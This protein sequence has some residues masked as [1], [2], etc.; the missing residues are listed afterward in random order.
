MR[1]GIPVGFRWGFGVL[2]IIAIAVIGVMTFVRVETLAAAASGVAY[3]E[4][5]RLALERSLSTLNDVEAGLRGYFM[6]RQE[7]FLQPYEAA[8]GRLEGELTAMTQ[9]A[10]YSPEQARRANELVRLARLR[11]QHLGSTLER[12]RSGRLDA[13]TLDSA[14]REGRA[15]MESVRAQV[16]AMELEESRQLQ[17]RLAA[18]ARARFLALTFTAA[19]ACVGAALVLMVLVIQSR[20]TAELRRSEQWLRTTLHSIGDAVIATDAEGM[21]RFQNDVA[22]ELT[23]WTEA[24]ARGSAL[25]EVFRIVSDDGGAVDSPVKRVLREGKIVG[26]ANH[27]LLIRRDGTRIPIE[28]SGAPIKDTRGHT[29][30]VVLVFKDAS[31]PRAAALALQSSEERLRLAL[32]AAELGTFDVEVATDRAIW[33]RQLYLMMGY[34]PGTVV[35]RSMRRAPLVPEDAEQLDRAMERA[36]ERRTSFQVEYRVARANDKVQRWHAVHGRFLY[37]EHGAPL[38]VVGVVQDVTDRRQ[39]E[40]RIRESQRLDA[41]GTLAAGIAHDFNN[42][43]AVMRGNLTLIETELAAEHPA[44]A[45]A[46]ELDAAC[47]R[48]A[49]LVRR[50]L[51]FGRRQEQDRRVVQLRDVVAETLKLLRATVP[52]SIEIRT[53]FADHIV[54]VLADVSQIHQVVMNLGINAAQAIGDRPGVITVEIEPVHVDAALVRSVPE[55]VEGNYVCLSFGDDGAGMS[56][57]VREHIF[58]PFFTTKAHGS[59]TGLGLSVVRGIVRNHDGAI[60]VT[61]EPGKGTRFQL[62]F[63]AVAEGS[64]EAAQAPRNAPATATLTSGAGLRVLFLDDEQALVGLAARLLQRLGYTVSGFTQAALA[65]EAFAAAPD[66][67]DIVVTDLSMPGLN[68]IEVARRMLALRPGLPVLLMSGYLRPEEAERAQEIGIREIVR[69]PAAIEELGAALARLRP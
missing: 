54:P 39:L 33:N 43:I 29:Q 68:G 46:A 6:T 55:L 24:E 9:L 18:A 13:A 57:E 27:A 5:V 47:A 45:A 26:L 20:A 21:V 16:G 2:A 15:L 42:M 59:G 48:A 52:A 37:D 12:A 36:L 64:I 67:F 3:S 50:I 25:D 38:R 66:A 1:Q 10:A 19:L 51:T 14:T 31:K 23:G 40:Q 4:R 62:Y 8:R 7:V 32:D 56:R 35:P 49:D 11:M 65:L 22:T 28:D 69:K 41:L 63:P 44:R 17:V 60:T 30:G 34:E 61:S 53:R 58:E